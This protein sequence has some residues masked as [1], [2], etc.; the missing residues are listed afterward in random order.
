MVTHRDYSLLPE[1]E[2]VRDINLVTPST[3]PPRDSPVSSSI[4]PPGALEISSELSTSSPP[5]ES[6][7]TTSSSS[8]F[9]RASS[10]T[11]FYEIT[12]FFPPSSQ[13]VMATHVIRAPNG[14]TAEPVLQTTNPTVAIDPDTVLSTAQLERALPLHRPEILKDLHPEGDRRAVYLAGSYAYPGIP[15]LEGCAGSARWVA[16]DILGHDPQVL[17]WDIGRGSLLGRAWRWRR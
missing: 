6:E 12:P 2:D 17:N 1:K 5:S 9:S 15:L 14:I 8:G 7:T 3:T 11:T 16:R 4:D 13:H 10:A